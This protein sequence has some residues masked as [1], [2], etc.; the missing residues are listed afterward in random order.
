MSKC[1]CSYFGYFF[2]P[3]TITFIMLYCLFYLRRRELTAFFKESSAIWRCRSIFSFDSKRVEVWYC[4]LTDSA[5]PRFPIRC[6]C[7]ES[8]FHQ[9]IKVK[10]NWFVFLT[11]SLLFTA[12]IVVEVETQLT[13][14]CPIS[15]LVLHI[16]LNAS[17]HS[18]DLL[19]CLCRQRPVLSFKCINEPY[20][21]VYG[22]EAHFFTKF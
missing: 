8:S 10:L 19:L 7:F 17:R 14:S 13:Q 3:L 2:M 12:N 11:T 6:R 5:L 15:S 21:L 18:F 20:K 16:A 22:I 9:W 4:K 1:S